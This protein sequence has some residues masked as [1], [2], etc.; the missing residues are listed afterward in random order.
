MKY[1]Y[2]R[3]MEFMKT[4]DIREILKVT[5]QPEVI[6]FAGGLPAAETFPKDEMADITRAVMQEYGGLALQY[7]TTEGFPRL[8]KAIAARMN[9]K[10]GTSVTSGEVLITSGS[11]QGLDLTG[12]VFLDEGDLVLC[13]SPT[14]LGALHAFQV[15][16]PRYREVPTDDEGMIIE[17]LER[18]LEYERP[19][20]I[21]VI[22]DFQNPTGRTWSLERRW[23]FMEVVNHYH[24]PVIED[25]PYS[26]VRFE[27]VNLLSLKS[28]DKLGLVIHLGTFSKIFCPGM[29][30]AWLVAPPELMN[31]YVMVKQGTD[32]H[33]SSLSQ[34]LLCAYMECHNLDA[35]I[36]RI[37]GLYRERR[38]VMLAAMDRCFPEGIRVTHPEGGLFLWV[39]LPEGAD[40]R[41]LLQRSIERK[42]AFV[43]GGSFFPNGGH[44]NTLRM[45]FSAMPPDRIVEGVERLAEVLKEYL[46]AGCPA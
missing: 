40:A 32:L 25:A 1:E 44:E 38:D 14:Y 20:F 29:R 5:G 17:E 6:S 28:F 8:R 46:H 37:R 26:E 21:Y 4:S 11:Q 35:N 2:A 9:L 27:G 3:R 30:L 34:L 13:E 24:V 23:A 7:S 43:P 22:P 10:R 45:N 39:E 18:M 19:K 33:T 42:V 31:Q 15:F 41:E 36:C 16:R 12:K